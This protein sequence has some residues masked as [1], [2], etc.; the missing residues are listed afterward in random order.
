MFFFNSNLIISESMRELIDREEAP[1]FKQL[2]EECRVRLGLSEV[3]RQLW[4]S[5][6][7]DLALATDVGYSPRVL[8]CRLP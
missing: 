7:P 3:V 1:T 8:R 4:N 6:M 5:R 2:L